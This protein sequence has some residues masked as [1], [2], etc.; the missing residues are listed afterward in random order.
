MYACAY[1]CIYIYIYT[2]RIQ[3]NMVVRVN[4]VTTRY[5]LLAYVIV[6]YVTSRQ[7]VLHCS[8]AVLL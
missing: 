5:V 6:H 4:H 8:I 3:H 7:S 1:V 2:H